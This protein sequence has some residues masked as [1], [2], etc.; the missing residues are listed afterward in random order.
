MW[1]LAPAEFFSNRLQFGQGLPVRRGL[2][3]TGWWSWYRGCLYS[4][5]SKWIF[6][7][8]LFFINH[9][10]LGLF[11]SISSLDWVVGSA[12]WNLFSCLLSCVI[13]SGCYRIRPWC[14]HLL[15]VFVGHV[16]RFYACVLGVASCWWPS[17]PMPFLDS[18]S[19]T[20][21]LC[22]VVF[23]VLLWYCPSKRCTGKELSRLIRAM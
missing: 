13:L 20:F 22:L 18:N 6:T 12:V 19:R 5:G 10:Q 23:S 9:L 4:I 15:R 3:V 17:W 21:S 8:A 2:P 1:F 11:L 7:P 14:L 16:S